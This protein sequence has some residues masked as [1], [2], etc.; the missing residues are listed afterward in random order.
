MTRFAHGSLLLLALLTAPSAAFADTI[1]LSADTGN[2]TTGLGD[3]SGSLSYDAGSGTLTVSLTNTSDP[4]NGGYITAFALNDPVLDASD[5]AALGFSSSSANFGVIFDPSTPPAKLGG[6]MTYELG[7]STSD[8]WLGNAG[9]HTGP[10]LG[11][12]VGETETFSFDFS[13]TSLAWGSWTASDFVSGSPILVRFRGFLND[14]SDK[15]PGVPGQAVPEPGSLAMALLGFL[16]LL[17]LG[18][19]RA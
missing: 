17:G 19:R 18:R 15:V 2:S 14:G 9:A 16:A 11:I 8:S 7:A 4:S 5:E 6:D 12:A 10:S 3:F 13:G 1:N